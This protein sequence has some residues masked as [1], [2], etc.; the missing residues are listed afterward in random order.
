MSLKLIIKYVIPGKRGQADNSSTML[1]LRDIFFLT[2]VSF[3]EKVMPVFICQ[4]CLFIRSA[5]NS[6][7]KRNHKQLSN[8]PP[9]G[10]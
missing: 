8:V 3:N 10:R 1:K 5:K 9:K 2:S 4:F 6:S 7:V